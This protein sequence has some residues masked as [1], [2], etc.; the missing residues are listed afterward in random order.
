[1]RSLTDPVATGI[2][3]G[4]VIGKLIGI[5]DAAWLMDRFTPATK[6]DDY[7]WLD[8]GGLAMVAGIGFTVSLLVAELSFVIGNPHNDDARVGIFTG[9][10]IAAVIGGSLLAVRNAHYKKLRAQ[11]VAVDKLEAPS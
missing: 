4:L 9:S 3:L 6:V 5:F 1:M 8:L 7:T 11:G 10:T 2:V